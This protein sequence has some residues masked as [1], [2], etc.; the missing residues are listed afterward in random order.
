[1]HHRTITPKPRGIT[2]PMVRSYAKNRNSLDLKPK[3]CLGK[4][5]QYRLAHGRGHRTNRA[6]SDCISGWGDSRVALSPALLERETGDFRC[7]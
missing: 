2:A 4:I 5:R 1:M 3:L 7:S 6:D